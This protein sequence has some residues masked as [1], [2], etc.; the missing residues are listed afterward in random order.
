MDIIFLTI[1]F[2]YFSS[3]KIIIY[4]IFLN[5][6]IIFVIFAKIHKTIALC[7]E[8]YFYQYLLLYR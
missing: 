7:L 1:V 6:S 4:F 2:L 3:A 8:H 5:I